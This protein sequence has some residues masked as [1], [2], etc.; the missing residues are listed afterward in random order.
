MK[1]IMTIFGATLFASLILTS[2]E[3]ESISRDV[4]RVKEIYFEGTVEHEIGYDGTWGLSV[5]IISGELAGK[6]EQFYFSTRF[7]DANKVECK[8]NAA[9]S[10]DRTG[11]KIKGKVIESTGEFENYEKGGYE[12]RKCYRPIKLTWI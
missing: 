12:T 10:P 5:E 4:E 1:N 3:G 6:A 2:C 11:K 7:D 8:G 9:S